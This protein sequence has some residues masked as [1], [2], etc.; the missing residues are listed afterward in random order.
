MLSI[1]MVTIFKNT[2]NILVT[3]GDWYFFSRQV[4]WGVIGTLGL[5]VLV[6]AK[7]PAAAAAATA[8]E[9]RRSPGERVPLA[10]NRGSACLGSHP[11]VVS[12][13]YPLALL[14]PCKV[15]PLVERHSLVLTERAS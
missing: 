5:M 8:A 15:G 4:S 3:A 2:N 6:C 7:P 10:R 12:L 14:S 9:T 13:T 11:L 1:P